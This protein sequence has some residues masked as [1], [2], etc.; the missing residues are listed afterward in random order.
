MMFWSDY[1]YYDYDWVTENAKVWLRQRAI[2]AYAQLTPY[3]LTDEELG[4]ETPEEGYIPFDGIAQP[5]AMASTEPTLFD[6][7]DMRGMQLKSKATFQN[8]RDGLRPGLYIV[9]G[10]K[11]LIK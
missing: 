7:Y 4:I 6:V 3:E 9:N 2:E 11:M 1:D 5:K 10:K 8:L